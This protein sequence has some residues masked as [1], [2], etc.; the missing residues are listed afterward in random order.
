MIWCGLGSEWEIGKV[1]FCI[2]LLDCRRIAAGSHNH[3]YQL[4]HVWP[5]WAF[6]IL[7]GVGIL[8][9]FGVFEKRRNDLVRLG[10]RMGDWE[11]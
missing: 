2:D 9:V 6:G 5:W 4:K 8:A 1:D 11:G 3:D 10:K 7:V